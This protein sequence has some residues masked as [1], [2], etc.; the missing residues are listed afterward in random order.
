MM[1]ARPRIGVLSFAHYHAN[2]WSEVFAKQGV[3]EGVWDDDAARGREAA[4]R[5]GVEHTPDLDGLLERCTAVAIC[6]E[7]VDHRALIDQAAKRRLAVLCEKPLGVSIDDCEQIARIV[8]SA[9]APLDRKS[10][11]L[12]SS[13]G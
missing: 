6:S 1:S 8:K 11:R 9:G 2:F 3:L 5:F 13:H 12:N 10:T 4:S 7:T